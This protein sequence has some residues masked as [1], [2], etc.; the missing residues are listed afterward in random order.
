MMSSA[1]WTAVSIFALSALGVAS[2]TF[3]G[4]TATSG[5]VN[6]DGGTGSSSGTSGTPTDS[7]ADAAAACPGN[8]KQKKI[9]ISAT[10]QAALDT[11]C[12]AELTACFGLA[13]V[14]DADG[15]PADDCNTFAD[16]IGLCSTQTDRAACE[17]ECNLGAPKA[18]QD[19]YDAITACAT[20]KANSSCQ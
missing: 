17:N 11:Q 5:T 10:C 20:A 14:P 1:K 9:I 18:I 7:G 12:C 6:D 13:P 3:G 19:A 16:C 2:L 4:C 15:G 8:T